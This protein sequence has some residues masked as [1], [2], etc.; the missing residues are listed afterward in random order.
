MTQIFLCEYALK[1]FSVSS[2]W[3][4]VLFSKPFTVLR[5]RRFLLKVA[6]AG[7]E[8]SAVAAVDSDYKIL[9]SHD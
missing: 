8:F 1:G 3:V 2:G 4:G 7:W 5:L 6:E 9:E